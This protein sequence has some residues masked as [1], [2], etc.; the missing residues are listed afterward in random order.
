[1]EKVMTLSISQIEMTPLFEL[2]TELSADTLSYML[3]SK[4]FSK[5]T[6]TE[7]RQKLSAFPIDMEYIRQVQDLLTKRFVK[8]LHGK[9][10]EPIVQA[11]ETMMKEQ[12]DQTEMPPPKPNMLGH[13]QQTKAMYEAIKKSVKKK[14]V[15]L[16]EQINPHLFKFLKT[17]NIYME[18]VIF[19]K[20][21]ESMNK[22]LEFVLKF[23]ARQDKVVQ[24]KEFK[25]LGLDQ[26][27]CKLEGQPMAR[28]KVKIEKKP[29]VQVQKKI[30]IKGAKDIFVTVDSRNTSQ[31]QSPGIS[32]PIGESIISSGVVS[33]SGEEKTEEEELPYEDEFY[34]PVTVP[35]LEGTWKL[36]ENIVEEFSVA[37]SGIKRLEHIIYPILKSD[38]VMIGSPDP[39]K[40]ASFKQVQKQVKWLISQAKGTPD[41]LITEI[42]QFLLYYSMEASNMVRSM[43]VECYKINKEMEAEE[44]QRKT[45]K[46]GTKKLSDNNLLEGTEETFSE[47]SESKPKED[48]ESVKAAKKKEEDAK[49]GP[50]KSPEE[51]FEE[52]VEAT[53]ISDEIMEDKLEELRQVYWKVQHYSDFHDFGIVQLDISHYKNSVCKRIQKLVDHL[54]KMVQKSFVSRQVQLRVC[55]DEIEQ[56]L[57]ADYDTIDQILE[58]IDF[59]KM[60]YHNG[61]LI[62]DL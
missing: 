1:M 37:L 33:L 24:R 12:F 40:L 58:Q 21:N 31:L 2:P 54:H 55:F 60:H 28:I 56:E 34:R 61:D 35:D 48:T 44:E 43:K 59:I 49:K 47:S 46:K 29:V 51:I 6:G 45:N 17:V 32:S 42:K 20:M 30:E 25:K 9:W 10:V 4:E 22:Y 7:L 23:M 19:D 27:A 62:N 39:E 36:L 11:I 13:N 38:R 18:R 3:S 50:Q 41:H 26:V 57:T 53:E 52:G 16:P 14:L 8:T 5:F 15:R